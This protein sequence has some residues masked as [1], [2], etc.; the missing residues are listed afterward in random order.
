MTADS[1]GM[2]ALNDELADKL[3]SCERDR[4]DLRTRLATELRNYQIEKE[5]LL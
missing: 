3:R 4:N 2:Q 1:R 5:E